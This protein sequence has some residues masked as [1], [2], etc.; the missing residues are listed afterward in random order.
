MRDS[1]AEAERWRRQAE[2]DLEFGRIAVREG[3][4]AQACVIAQQSAEK[5][6]KSMAYAAGERVVLGHSLVEL[7]GRLRAPEPAVSD[8][9][10]VA[11]ILDQYYVA[12]RY[13]SGLPGGTPFEAFSARQAREAI[14][15][16]ERFLAL[17]RA[18]DRPPPTV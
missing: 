8:L 10:E 11:G 18:A 4:F 1:R 13:P 16:T 6:L 12:T 9:M 15:A 2:N 3:F 14:S 7:V 17:V 5:A